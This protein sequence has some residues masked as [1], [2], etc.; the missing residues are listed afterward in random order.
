MAVVHATKAHPLM[1]GKGLFN[2]IFRVPIEEVSAHAGNFTRA[3]STV[4][5]FFFE[6]SAPAISAGELKSLDYIGGGGGD[7]VQKKHMSSHFPN[8]RN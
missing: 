8:E 4:A 7:G 5:F 6:H 3:S 2:F 1:H